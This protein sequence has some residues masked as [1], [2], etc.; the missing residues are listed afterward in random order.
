MEVN[1]ARKRAYPAPGGDDQEWPEPGLPRGA[2]RGRS[3]GAAFRLQ[4][5]PTRC[6]H[7][8]MTWPSSIHCCERCMPSG[9]TS[10]SLRQRTPPVSMGPCARCRRNDAMALG[11]LDA[12]REAARAI[13]IVG[14]NA[15]PEGV[16]A[17]KA[18]EAPGRGCV[19]RNETG[20]PG[21]RGRPSRPG[22]RAGAGRDPS[23][24]CGGRACQLLRLG[25]ALHGT[26]TP[27][28]V[29]VRAGLK[30]RRRPRQSLKLSQRTIF[31]CGAQHQWASYGQFQDFAE[32]RLENE[33]NLG[34]SG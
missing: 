5:S 14:V 20:V 21:R 11:A 1:D 13:P 27:G 6:P 28:L 8:P 10:C 18:G 23:S 12:M 32:R 4:P 25:L 34:C 9:P 3:G 26:R 24:R 33:R 16:A 29:G 22:P 17:I 30:A 31:H 19:R 7:G 2:D 15:T